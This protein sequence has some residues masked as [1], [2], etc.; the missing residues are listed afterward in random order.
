MTASEAKTWTPE[1]IEGGKADPIPTKPGGKGPK[2]TDYLTP[3]GPG[4]LFLVKPRKFNTFLCLEFSITDQSEKAVEL[5]SDMWYL[6]GMGQEGDEG[7]NWVVPM[8]FCL[9]FD[10][11]DIVKEGSND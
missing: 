9:A 5:F 1:V 10:L 11:I 4:T 7:K 3:M 6:I 2:D 8:D